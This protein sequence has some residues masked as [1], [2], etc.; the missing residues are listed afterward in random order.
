MARTK[1]FDRDEALSR[2][3]G[4]FAQHGYEGTSTPALLEAMGI[5]RQSLYDTFGDKWRLYLEALRRYSSDSVGAQL[6]V[7]ESARDGAA[8]VEALLLR[9]AAVASAEAHP[10]CLGVSAICE[11]GRSAPE[12]VDL[13]DALGRMLTGAIERRVREAVAAG[14][15]GADLDPAAAAGFVLATL[16]GIK[17]AARMGADAGALEGIARMALRGFR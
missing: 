9:A 3:I 13:N 17:V 6:L 2:A 8:G 1:A 14:R 10:A 7:L 15:F 4:L 16:T 11:F 5:G 12:I